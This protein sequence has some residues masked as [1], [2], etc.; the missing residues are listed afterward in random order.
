MSRSQESAVSILVGFTILSLVFYQYHTA[1]TAWVANS[2]ILVKFAVYIVLNPVYL[3][4]MLYLALKY[5]WRGFLSSLFIIMALDIQSLPHMVGVNGLI[6][7][8]PTSSM[9]VDALIYKAWPGIDP[10]TLYIVLPTL[11]LVGAYLAVSPR[12]FVKTFK[13]HVF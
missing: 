6:D 12:N 8:S 1:I 5:Q 3:G 7:G 2:S 9:F 13:Q 4:L 10:F 11:L